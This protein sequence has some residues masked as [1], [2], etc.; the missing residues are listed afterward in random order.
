[1][2]KIHGKPHC[3]ERLRD[4]LQRKFIGFGTPIDSTFEGG[5]K[6]SHAAGTVLSGYGLPETLRP[7]T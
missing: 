1:M 7:P 6:D 3:A 2:Y 4:L 5:L